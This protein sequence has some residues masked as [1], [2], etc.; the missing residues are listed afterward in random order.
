MKLRPWLILSV[1]LNLLL[2]GAVVWAALTRA[3]R[4]GRRLISRNVTNRVESA[5]RTTNAAVSVVVEVAAP[6]NWQQVES[7]DYRVYVKNLR[8]IGCPEA[9]IRDII[10][11]DVNEWF[12]GRIKELVDGV[13]G[14]F[15]DFMLNHDELEKLVE[16]KLK[17]LNALHDEREEMFASLFG[18]KDPGAKIREA[19]QEKEE[20]AR[21]RQTLDFL[22]GDKLAQFLEIKDRF[23]A[24][25]QGLK[26]PGNTL[27]HDERERKSQEL[28]LEEERQIHALFTPQELD[29]YKLR[30][31][32]VA[33]FRLGLADFEATE[34]ELRAI[35]RAKMNQK[36]APVQGQADAEIKE[37]LGAERFAAYQRAADDAYRQTLRITDRFELTPETAVQVYQMQKEAEAQARKIRDDTNRPVEERQAI[38]E[39]MQDETEKS[40][41]AV[42]GSKVF[43]AYQKY[44]DGW[45]TRFAEGVR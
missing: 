37:L 35:A 7:A 31:S 42:L 15:W 13:A 8:A 33:G 34:E 17:E 18:E 3:G 11:A 30:T 36:Q 38:L 16:E 40:I 44:G 23:S 41:S 45:L 27:T 20:R 5:R 12:A 4:E 25:R 9:T 21:W 2:A 39:I 28:N 29:E 10:V 24:A 32:S 26:Q 14:R 1:C 19:E 6:F 43:G 22:P